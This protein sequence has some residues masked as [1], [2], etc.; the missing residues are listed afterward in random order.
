MDA[1]PADKPKRSAFVVM[2]VSGSGK[3]TVGR[4]LALRLEAVFIDADDLHSDTAK[5]KM[6]RGTPLTDDDRAPW[7][8]R[9]AARITEEQFH[10]GRVVV[11]CSALRRTY[12]DTLRTGTE[13][14]LFFAHLH[15]DFDVLSGRM[16]QRSGHFM[17]TE[18]LQSQFATLEPLEA[19]EIGTL[20]DVTLEPDA[21][22]QRLVSSLVDMR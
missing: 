2:G 1:T 19:D 9:I 7:L 22:A 13:S 8:R 16:S 18:L 3:S 17:P 11:A 12:R 14:P 5:F 6:S 20:I 4:A 15:G 10:G 21:I